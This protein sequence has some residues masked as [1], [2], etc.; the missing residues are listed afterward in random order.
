MRAAQ[1]RDGEAELRHR[2]GLEVLHEH[3]GAREHRREQRLVVGAREIEH[4]G[5]LAAVEP[6][7]IAALAVHQIV[8]AAREIALRP[9]DLDDARAGVGEPARAHRTGDGLFERDDEE[10]GEG[11]SHA[12]HP[13]IV[14]GRRHAVMHPRKRM[15]RNRRRSVMALPEHYQGPAFTG[16]PPS[17]A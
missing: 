9:L 3:V 4:H 16:C 6:D 11:E 2:A 12:V 7:E 5:F 8:I 1:L 14:T 17:R 10:A 15:I 13:A